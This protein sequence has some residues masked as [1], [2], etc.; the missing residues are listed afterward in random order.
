MKIHLIGIKGS[1]MSALAKFLSDMGH[2]VEGSDKSIYIFTE[3]LLKNAG[4]KIMNFDEIDYEK[5][6]FFIAGHD[7]YNSIYA[8][9]ALECNKQVYEYNIYLAKIANQFISTAVSGSHGKTTTTKMIEEIINTTIKTSYLIGDGEGKY[10]N[11][12]NFFVFEACEY[13]RHFLAYSCDTHLILNVDLDHVDYFKDNKDYETA[14][15]EFALLTKRNLVVNG[16]DEF[17]NK[18]DL[19]GIN[20]YK[21]GLKEHNRFKAIN[22]VDD[23][24]GLSYDLIIDGKNEGR[25][26]LNKNGLHLVYNSLAALTVAYIYQI[27]MKNAI[28][29]LASF[30]G[31]NRR[32]VETIDNDEVYID[33]YAHHFNEIKATLQAAKARYPKRKIIAIFRPDRHSRILKFIPEFKEALLTADVAYVVNFPSTSKNDTDVEF[34]ARILTDN[35]DIFF[36]DESEKAYKE[37]A[38]YHNVVYVFM[39]SKDLSVIARKIRDNKW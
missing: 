6:D 7:F 28:S 35:Q 19:K 11:A 27:D 1:G 8:K 12:S 10:I 15:K 21:Y 32:S 24:H 5:Y 22:I 4:I 26:K 3:V 30:S 29:S 13:K 23:E 16:D 25:V 38:T 18:L 2:E 14:F 9:K 20:I 31:V 39:S 37:L 33:D 17:L 34:D 36:F